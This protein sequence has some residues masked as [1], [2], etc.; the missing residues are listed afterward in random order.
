MQYAIN[1]D[2][3]TYANFFLTDTDGSST[4]GTGQAKSLLNVGDDDWVCAELKPAAGSITCNSFGIK[5]SGDDSSAIPA[6]FE[7][8]DISIVYRPK[9]VK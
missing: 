7:I 4:N 1:G 8:N 9:S 3:D 5:I 6:D 2:D